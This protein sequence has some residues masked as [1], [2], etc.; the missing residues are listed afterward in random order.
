MK[1]KK[2][3]KPSPTAKAVNLQ[4]KK[5]RNLYMQTTRILDNA[6]IP[7]DSGVI[8]GEK[9]D[10]ILA[11]FTILIERFGELHRTLNHNKTGR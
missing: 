7:L 10:Q 6:P 8:V 9:Y 4:Y 3:R 1:N 5:L 2:D 11:D